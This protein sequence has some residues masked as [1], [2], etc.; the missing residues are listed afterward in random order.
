MNS[1][2]TDYSDDE[3]IS[4]TQLKKEAHAQQALGE[5]LTQLSEPVLATL[6]LGDRLLGAILEYKRLPSRHGALKRQLQF[7]GKLMR[8]CDTDAISA[9]LDSEPK[10]QKLAQQVKQRAQEQLRVIV[11]SGDEGIQSV[12]EELPILDRQKTRQLLRAIHAAK[13]DSKRASA[14]QRLLEYLLELNKAIA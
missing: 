1:N 12:L 6:P 14:E 9:L 11:D 10:T 5:R 3:F 2:D 8:D 4:K 13:D 7:I